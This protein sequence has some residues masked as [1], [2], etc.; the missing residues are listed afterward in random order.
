MFLLFL[1]KLFWREVLLK[2]VLVNKFLLTNLLHLFRLHVLHV[3]TRY[4]YEVLVGICIDPITLDFWLTACWF[5]RWDR[6]VRC[7]PIIS[8]YFPLIVL[9][10][11]TQFFS[12]ILR[13]WRFYALSYWWYFSYLN[14]KDDDD[15]RHG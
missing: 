4:S 6:V 13:T 1:Q 2:I 9:V 7:A 3:C 10:T 5:R 8:L 11:L 15:L 12:K 14:S